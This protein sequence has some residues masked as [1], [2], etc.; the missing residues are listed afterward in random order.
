MRTVGE[1]TQLD[2]RAAR[3]EHP[4][5]LPRPRRRNVGVD[6]AA[7]EIDRRP[8]E[9]RLNRPGR[10]RRSDDAAGEDQGGAIAAR[11][12]NERLR[13]ETRALRETAEDDPPGRDALCDDAFDD[14]GMVGKGPAQ[15]RFVR[16]ERRHEALRIPRVAGCARQHEA[17]VGAIERGGELGHVL[18][19]AAAAMGQDGDRPGVGGLRP[20]REQTEVR[21]GE[22]ARASGMS[23][24]VRS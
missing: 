24:F 20:D 2:E 17:H 9:R 13:R 7:G 14:A 5:R 12:A 4:R 8:G 16:R 6:L 21:H 15:P 18:G 1:D 11:S 19:R 3:L 23:C 22:T 10:P